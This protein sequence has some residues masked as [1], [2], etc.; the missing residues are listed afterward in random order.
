MAVAECFASNS[1]ISS[2]GSSTKR[3]EN[4]FFLSNQDRELHKETVQSEGEETREEAATCKTDEKLAKTTLRAALT[5][6]KWVE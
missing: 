3:W 2:P 1:Y 6:F 4:I 5:R